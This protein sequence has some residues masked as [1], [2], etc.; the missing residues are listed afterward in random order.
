MTTAYAAEDFNQNRTEL[1]RGVRKNHDQFSIEFRGRPFAAVLPYDQL[2]AER[3]ELAE[4]RKLVGELK[5]QLDE[6]TD[7]EK[8]IQNAIETTA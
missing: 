7:L 4:L 2:Q 6:A 3:A 8:K 5:K 1:M